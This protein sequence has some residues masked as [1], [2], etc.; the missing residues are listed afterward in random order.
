MSDEETEVQIS[1]NTAQ[2]RKAMECRT[3]IKVQVLHTSLW[4]MSFL[5]MGD[6]MEPW[7]R[8]DLWQSL[9]G[10]LN[11]EDHTRQTGTPAL[12]TLGSEHQ[13]PLTHRGD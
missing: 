4:S 10:T 5:L 8:A 12:D 6:Q 1:G 3:Q 9:E 13:K 11:Q 2:A 7:S